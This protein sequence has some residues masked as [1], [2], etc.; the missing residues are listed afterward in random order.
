MLGVNASII[1]KKTACIV[2][3]SVPTRLILRISCPHAQRAS[4]AFLMSIETRRPPDYY[5][6]PTK[7]SKHPLGR[8]CFCRIDAGRP[9]Q[10]IRYFW[11]RS[12]WLNRGVRVGCALI[13]W[14]PIRKAWHSN[15]RS[16]SEAGPPS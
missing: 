13:Q 10:S 4:W 6:L 11:R 5:R 15:M 3:I 1:P 16:R 7:P 12:L 14:G 9:L 2:V 8:L